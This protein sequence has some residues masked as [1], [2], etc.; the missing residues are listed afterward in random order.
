MTNK[1][2]RNKTRKG[3]KKKKN[4][5][6]TCKVKFFNMVQQDKRMKALNSISLLFGAKKNL[7][8]ELNSVLNSKDIQNN[9]LVKDCVR[10]C[11]K[12]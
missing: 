10:D 11:N 3:G 12:Q 9:K 4:C 8:K 7:D 1:I 5:K 2:K 6:T